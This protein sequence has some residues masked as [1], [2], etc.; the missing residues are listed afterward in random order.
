MLLLTGF[1]LGVMAV[2]FLIVARDFGHLN[3][4]KAF[5]ALLLAGSFFVIRPHLPVDLR[6]VAS[7]ISTMV[8]ALFWLLCRVAFSY[9]PKVLSFTG[10]LALY[11]FTAPALARLLGVPYHDEDSIWYLLGW[12]IPRYCEYVIISLGLWTVWANREDDLVESRRRLR[13][14]VLTGVGTSV[15]LVVVPLNTGVV[16]VWL[17]YL[18]ISVIALICAYSLMRGRNGVLFGIPSQSPNLPQE[19][20]GVQE[21]QP[22]SEQEANAILLKKTMSEGFYRTEHL[23]LKILAD[24]L[25][26]PEYRT[27][28]LINQALGY[29]NFNDYINQLRICEA[30]QLLLSDVQTPVLNISLDVGYRTLSSFNRAFKDIQNMS[31]SEYRQ[32]KTL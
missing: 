8:P 6:S 3:V 4:G 22:D 32:Q 27:R 25:G 14:L 10:A 7:D 19:I 21:S 18:S 9:R 16:G 23:T 5:L 13:G 31:P 20:V 29:R 17:P 12:H 24:Q 1:A 30:A 28:A 2:T 26:L 15:L 11:T